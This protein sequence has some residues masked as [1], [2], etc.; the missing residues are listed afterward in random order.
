MLDDSAPAGTEPAEVSTA[1]VS[2]LR[3]RCYEALNDDRIR[4]L[5]LPHC[6]TH[7]VSSIR[8]GWCCHSYGVGY[9]RAEDVFTLFLVDILGIRTEMVEGASQPMP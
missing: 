6:L 7:A 4:R 3:A 8:Q 9:R 5:S 2:G 1:E